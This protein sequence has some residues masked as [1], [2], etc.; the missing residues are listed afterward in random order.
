[1]QRN[2]Q[3]EGTMHTCNIEWLKPNEKYNLKKIKKKQKKT[4]KKRPPRALCS[5]PF[6][7]EKCGTTNECD[8]RRL[9]S[10]DVTGR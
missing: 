2:H 1:M 3:E 8:N 4:K 6:K 10:Q 5:V 7:K 9:E